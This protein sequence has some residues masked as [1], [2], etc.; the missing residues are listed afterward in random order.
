MASPTELP[1]LIKEFTDMSKEY[2][3]QETVEPAKELGRY[4]GFVFAA[5]LC[6]ALGAVLL[7]IAGVRLIIDVLPEGPNWSALGYLLA[8]V[9]LA[10]LSGL[11]IKLGSTDRKRN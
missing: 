2:L 11:M 1:E 4:G 5:A 6:F 7:G 9:V 8:T 10:I 3:L